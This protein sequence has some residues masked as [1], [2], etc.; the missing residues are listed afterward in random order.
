LKCNKDTCGCDFNV[1]IP[2]DYSLST[3]EEL[4][5]KTQVASVCGDKKI[6]RD[7]DCDPPNTLCTTSTD[8]AG[9]CTQDC[10]CEIPGMLEPEEEV[11]VTENVTVNITEE[12]EEPEPVENITVEPKEEKKGFF[13]KLWA[14]IVALFS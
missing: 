14:W 10:K 5:N 8:E 12:I 7:E 9:V 6:E 1:S 3:V 13:A 4:I 11:N 2:K